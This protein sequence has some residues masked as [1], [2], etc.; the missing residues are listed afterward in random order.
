[1]SKL[2]SRMFLFITI[3]ITLSSCSLGYYDHVS[4]D[5]EELS[6]YEI[7]YF[8]DHEKIRFAT[9]QGKTSQGYEFWV[10][11][12]G[13]E[14]SIYGSRI[15]GMFT[16][17][18]DGNYLA[19]LARPYS[20]TGVP[21]LYDINANEYLKCDIN[22]LP[23]SQNRVWPIEEKR[24]VSADIRGEKD[25]VVTLDFETCEMETLYV[26]TEKEE[27]Q[28]QIFEAA[29]SSLGWIAITRYWKVPVDQFEIL[30]ISPKGEEYIIEN[31]GF[32]AWSK[33]GEKLAFIL[34][35]Q[36]VFV[37]NMTGTTISQIDNLPDI[38]LSSFGSDLVS[39]SPDGKY[40]VY[41]YRND[42][43]LFNIEEST[44]Q[45]IIEDGTFPNWRNDL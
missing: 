24:V 8:D 14:K 43:Y 4:P 23:E 41:E 28:E 38:Y 37:S 7:V 12:P 9:T 25:R 2:V 42:I 1:M 26:A 5:L 18:P 10:I 15:L 33:D 45:L 34:K 36:G 44:K 35:D 13:L 39:W 31:A 32:P 27:I 22:D 40:V 19:F 30:I 17:S 21:V 11:T 3:L 6:E 29:V 20:P 16:W